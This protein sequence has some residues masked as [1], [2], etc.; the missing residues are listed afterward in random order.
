MLAELSCLTLIAMQ[1]EGYCDVLEGN[2]KNTQNG[3]NGQFRGILQTLGPLENL[4]EKQPTRL[5][6]HA[7]SGGSNQLTWAS[8]VA[9]SSPHFAI[10]R[11]GG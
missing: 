8:C 11:R 6:E 9:I 5:G 4:K 10:N 3:G 1:S 2:E 7:A